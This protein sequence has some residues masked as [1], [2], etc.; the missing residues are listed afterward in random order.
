MRAR[1]ACRRTVDH[2]SEHRFHSNGSDGRGFVLSTPSPADE[3]ALAEIMLVRLEQVR[4]EWEDDAMDD[5]PEDY[6]TTAFS[7]PDLPADPT[8][9]PSQIH[10]TWWAVREDCDHDLDCGCGF[11]TLLEVL[12][13]LDE[14]ARALALASH[15]AVLR[16]VWH[17]Y[18]S[19][20]V[21]IEADGESLDGTCAWC[22]VE[23]RDH[24]VQL[25][26]EACDLAEQLGEAVAAFDVSLL[27][28]P[29]RYK[30]DGQPREN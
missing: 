3:E 9:G 29:P 17:H 1:R 24:L 28:G 7:F 22:I 8:V 26:D 16:E 2:V 4:V 20:Q 21:L 12:T 30:P 15:V 23:G 13:G 25:Y 19:A 10:P 18:W 27:S 6:P 5:D 14:A 11:V